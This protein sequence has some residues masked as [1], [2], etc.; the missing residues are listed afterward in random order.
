MYLTLEQLLVIQEALEFAYDAKLREFE[1]HHCRFDIA[2]R[3]RA[4]RAARDVK[5]Y[6]EL[7][8]SIDPQE[9]MAS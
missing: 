7:L 9:G 4:T 5:K 6:A 2:S 8:E 3:Q 1:D